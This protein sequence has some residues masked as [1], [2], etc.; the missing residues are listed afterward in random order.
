[1]V[2]EFPSL[3]FIADSQ[4]DAFLGIVDTV[5]HAIDILLESGGSIPSSMRH[6]K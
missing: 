3:S 1:V 5:K 6:L 2:T 4:N